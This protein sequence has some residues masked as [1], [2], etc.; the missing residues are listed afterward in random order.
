ML[1]LEQSVVDVDVVLHD[2]ARLLY[3][4]QNRSDCHGVKRPFL[5][6]VMVWLCKGQFCVANG[7]HK[8]MQK[9]RTASALE[10]ECEK[11]SYVAPPF[12]RGLSGIYISYTYLHDNCTF[13]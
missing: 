13:N 5:F 12:I 11:Y 9:R 4:R 6:A 8:K 7:R 2:N 10:R 1:V 3:A